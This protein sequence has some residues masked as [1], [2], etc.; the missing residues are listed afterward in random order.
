MNAWAKK[1]D[2]PPVWLLIFI[3]L[4]W[5]QTQVWNPASYPSNFATLV[6]WGIVAG[7][8][9]LMG[10]SFVMFL[11]HKTS[12]VPKRTPKS[13]IKTGPYKYSRNP[14]YLADALVLFG[15]ILTQGSVISFI[16]IPLFLWAISARFING[17]EAGIRA[18]FGQEFEDYC[19]QT[20]RWV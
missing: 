7:G 18:E 9:I 5:V 13:I 19:K 4:S 2:L 6:G 1:L 14:I 12:V 3:G 11:R 16:L 15:F 20:R 17:E 8:I 10:V